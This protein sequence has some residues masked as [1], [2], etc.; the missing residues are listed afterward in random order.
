MAVLPHATC[1]TKTRSVV[2]GSS[3]RFRHR[4]RAATHAR[5]TTPSSTIHD[6]SSLTR[7]AR[8]AMMAIPASWNAW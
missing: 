4:W 7:C 3:V 8:S 2:V 1:A 5:R 6:G